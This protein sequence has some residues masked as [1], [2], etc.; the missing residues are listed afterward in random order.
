MHIRPATKTDIPRLAALWA[1][2][3]P[4]ERTVEQRIRQLEAGGVYGGI[5]NAFVAEDG[6]T[7]VGGFRPYA[8]EQFI[9]GSLV[10][11]MGLAAVAVTERARRAGI[12]AEMCRAALRHAWDRGDVLSALYPFRPSYYEALGWSLVG[13]LHAYRFA[14]SSLPAPCDASRVRYLEDP[15]GTIAPCYARIAER[16]HGLIRRTPRIWRQHLEWPDVRAFAL[17][18]NGEC[19]A[20]ALVHE[21][22]DPSSSPMPA[23]TVRE[24]MAEDDASY[25]TMLSWLSKHAKAFRVVAHDARPSERFDLRLTEPRTPL[26]PV[27][28]TLFAEVA[29]VLRGPML[30]VVN[31][32]KALSVRQDWHVPN[33][34]CSLTVTDE[35]V[36]GNNGSFELHIGDSGRARVVRTGSD[37]RSSE[38]HLDCDIQGLTQ[39]YLGETSVSEAVRLG[40][41]TVRGSVAHMDDI[42]RVTRE[43]VLMDE[44]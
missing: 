22:S 7:L 35:I 11:A 18:E 10:P 41:A 44:F 30:R 24:L 29:N 37:A 17:I 36:A 27:A 19:H 25:R 33:I 20:Y 9:H 15:A 2:A 4:G 28:R 42:F 34:R 32:E 5:E 12:G 38:H 39:I 26:K 21:Q 40:R 6:N 14:P 31:V 23:L 8:L 1:E 3:F 43:F 16:S 13:T